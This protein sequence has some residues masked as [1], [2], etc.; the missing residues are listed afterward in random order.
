MVST[1]QPIRAPGALPRLASHHSPGVK[2]IT[3]RFQLHRY[4][5]FYPV[6]RAEFSPG[7][8]K[9][10]HQDALLMPSC[11]IRRGHPCGQAGWRADVSR[12]QS[13]LFERNDWTS[14]FNDRE[15]RSLQSARD[16]PTTRADN[17]RRR[18]CPLDARTSLWVRNALA[19]HGSRSPKRLRRTPPRRHVPPPY[20][21]VHR[22]C[23]WFRPPPRR[24]ASSTGGTSSPSRTGPLHSR[25]RKQLRLIWLR[26]LAGRSSPSSN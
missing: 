22:R 20:L 25:I 23:R 24:R 16:H 13:S 1:W 2:K 6:R 18:Q 9:P 14:R 12:V 7:R 10:G 19:S 15:R 8:S 11:A 17:R 3:S 21:V 5:Q 26:A 4:S